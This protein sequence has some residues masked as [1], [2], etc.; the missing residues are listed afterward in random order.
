[1]DEKYKRIVDLL[2]ITTGDDPQELFEWI[3]TRLDIPDDFITSLNA[4]SDDKWDIFSSMVSR[5]ILFEIKNS[6]ILN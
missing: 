2:T 1:M 6:N 5:Q 4:I 3:K